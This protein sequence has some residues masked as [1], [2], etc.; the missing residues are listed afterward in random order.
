MDGRVTQS[1]TTTTLTRQRARFR[2]HGKFLRGA[3]GDG[4]FRYLQVW[5]VDV[6]EVVRWFVEGGV[7]CVW[8]V[9]KLRVGSAALG[10]T[11]TLLLNSIAKR[12][13]EANKKK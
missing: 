13:R 5:A 9:L 6:A 2:A 12:D 7:G 3:T 4:G 10:C 8:W 1:V 11:P